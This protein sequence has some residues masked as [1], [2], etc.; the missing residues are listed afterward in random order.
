MAENAVYD[1]KDNTPDVSTKSFNELLTASEW[2]LALDSYQ[3]GFVWSQAKMAQMANDLLSY[4]KQSDQDLPYYMG[5][6]LLHAEDGEQLRFFF[7]GQQRITALSILHRVVTSH[8]PKG[9]QLSYSAKSARNI[10]DAEK[11]LLEASNDQLADSI[12]DRLMFTVIVVSDA[13]LA[14]TFFDTQNNRGVP[15]HATDLLKAYHLRAIDQVKEDS[16]KLDNLQEH[17]AGRW[18]AIQGYRLNPS[19]TQDFVLNLFSKFLW[20]ARRW[21]GGQ[22]HY[23]QHDSLIEEFQANTWP[24]SFDDRASVDTLPLYPSNHNRL[25]DSMT[26]SSNGDRTLHG[27]P[28]RITQEAAAMPMAI[29]QPIHQ[30]VG[31]FLYADKYAALLQD[32]MDDQTNNQE[33]KTFQKIYTKLVINNQVYLRDAFLLS[34]LV[35]VDQ[36]HYER[37][38]EFALR[39]EYILGGIRLDK[40]QVRYETSANFFKNGDLNLLDIIV[41]SYH[42]L[43]TI[44]FLSK[45]QRAYS[46]IY[47]K[48]SVESGKGVQGRYKEAN[49]KFFDSWGSEDKDNLSSKELWVD[50]KIKGIA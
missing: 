38:P 20:R 9:Q 16:L 33:L 2:P 23:G 13:D 11:T 43:Q 40:Q 36:F 19:S 28:I 14:F 46:E 27:S 30:G 42:P 45:K 29:R 15:L 25:A 18:E 44:Q 49:L 26:L 5:T 32:L 6:I 37:L 12:F 1:H 41:Q 22:A 7:D 39:L 17:C 47:R 3:R 4:Q 31:F 8:L 50:N 34:S 24:L 35:Y 10:L 48:E 21:R